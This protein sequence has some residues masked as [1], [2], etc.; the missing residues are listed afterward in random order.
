MKSVGLTVAAGG[1]M[2]LVAILLRGATVFVA[3]PA[4]VLAYTVALWAMGGIEEDQVAMIKSMF[5]RKLGR[6]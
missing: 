2:A 1:V 6:G 5:A 4:S 3:A